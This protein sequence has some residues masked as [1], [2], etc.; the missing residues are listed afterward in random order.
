MDKN[1]NILK[2]LGLA[3][4]EAKVYVAM[5]EIG[6]ATVLEIAGRAGINRPTA[7]LQ[8]ESL[9]KMG[10]ISSH[11]KGKRQLFS[12]E[13]P[14]RLSTLLD[15]QKIEIET[16]KNT[17]QKALPEL[18]TLFNLGEN[19][20]VV[21]YFE[22]IEGL[23]AIQQDFLTSKEKMI[24]GIFSLDDAHKIFPNSNEEYSKMRIQK[25]ISSKMVY[26]SARGALYKRDDREKLREAKY[27]SPEKLPFSAD[28]TI[29]DNKI[30]I[31]LLQDPIG[32]TIIENNALAESFKGLFNLIWESL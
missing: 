5:L 18:T 32:G 31:S 28:I 21:R 20:P 26:T 2:D 4:K 29:Y 12:A 10:L 23:K 22:G 6:P 17:L 7:Y 11:N 16:K 15:K 14:D 19:K 9:K 1:I 8:I 3:D 30:A 27:I 25:K 13:E 24:Y